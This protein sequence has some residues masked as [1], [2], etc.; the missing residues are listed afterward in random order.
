MAAVLAR[1]ALAQDSG[2]VPSGGPGAIVKEAE[3]PAE[4]KKPVVVMPELVKFV[5]APYPAQAQKDGVQADVVLKLTIDREGRVTAAEVTEPAGR[6]FDEAA[7]EAALQFQYK[8]ATRDGEPIPVQILYRYSF[9]LTPVAPEEAPPPPTSGNLS[10]Q[11]RIADTDTPFVGAKVVVRLPDGS[12]RTLTTDAQ[13]RFRLDD[14]AAGTYGVRI[15]LEG[16]DV[17]DSPEEVVAG[18]ETE[19]TLRVAAVSE[20]IEIVVRGERPQREVTRRTVERREI[21]RIPGTGGDALRSLQSLPG[22]ARPPGFAGLLI[23]RGSAPTGTAYFVDGADVPLIYHFGGL[24][25]VVPTELLDRI[26]FYPGNF[27]AR[28]G[29]VSGGIVDVG[30]RSP[31]TRCFT[32]GKVDPKRKGCYHAMLQA[33]LID[34]RALVQGPLPIEGFSF[35]LAGRRSWFDT[36][37]RPALEEAGSSVTSAPVYYDYQALA[38]RKTEDSRIALRAY[39][40][41]DR[42]EVIITDPAA[43]DPAFGGNV[44]FGTSFFRVQALYEADLNRKISLTSMLSAGRDQIEFSL[45]TFF[46]NIDAYP[47]NWRHEF[48]WKLFDGAKLNAGF[49]FQIAPFEVNVRAPQPPRPGEPDP[50]PFA[51]RPPLEV[52]TKGTVFRPAWFAEFELTPIDRLRL[53][54]GIRADFARDTGHADVAPRANARFDLIKGPSEEAPERRRTTLKGGAG[55]FYEPPQFQE[56]DEVF[57]T[58]GL[59]SNKSIHYALGVEQELTRQIDVSVE[60]FYKDLT[61]QVS[62]APEA[63]GGFGYANEGLGSVVGLETFLKY[64]PDE[65]FFGWLAYTLSR[66]VRQ[67]GPAEPEYLFQYDQTHNLIVLGS[68]RLGRG[69][70][71]GARFRVVSGP[72][73]TPVLQPPSLPSLYA[74]DAGAYAQLQGQPFSKRMPVFHQ[75]D[76]R[77]DKRWQAKD[78]RFSTYLDVQNVY[79]N[80]AV[81]GLVYNYNAS[82]SYYQTGVPILPSIGLRLEI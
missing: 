38:E 22:V 74:A 29:R 13:G 68:Y 11:L 32:K 10:G 2:S 30:L 3:P 70:E 81:E 49:D 52:S 73:Q 54:P 64:K 34:L 40:S 78:F 37:L 21:E 6:G 28:Y 43:E 51:S 15:E 55:Y 60:G 62:R 66:S 7:R 47:V 65:R 72:L 61:N 58:P 45:G 26:D 41:D 18:E 46:F 36:W 82:K 16:F 50:G 33:D 8:P 24:S 20:G 39:G 67:E 56:T 25:S 1:P 14:V 44:R 77:I 5:S 31:D 59:E 27:S 35:A 17:I 12:A 23:V 75:L 76:L 79:N 19:V 42:F 69:W 9:T 57:G 80:S 71:F 63:A 53:V 48:T 4:A